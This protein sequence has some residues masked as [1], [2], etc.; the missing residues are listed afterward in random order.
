MRFLSTF[1]T[2][3]L[4]TLIGCSETPPP[5]WTHKLDVFIQQE[6]TDKGIPALSITIVDNHETVWTQGYGLSDPL[7]ETYVT[8]ETVYRVASISK[9]FTALAVMQL[10][11]Q[12][13]LDLDVPITTYLPDFQPH[14]PFDTPITLRHLLSH[15]S[16]LVREP[17]RGHYFDPDKPTLENVVHSLNNTRLIYKPGTHEK[18]SNAGISVA[19]YILEQTQ[20]QLFESYIQEAVIHPLKLEKTSF[21]PRQDIRQDLGIGYMWRYD[22]STLTQAPVF[23]LGI[24]PAANLYTTTHDLGQFICSLFAI[25]DGKH[26]DILQ[27]ETLEDM[28]TPQGKG[29]NFGLGFALSEFEQH[30]RVQHAGV[31]YGYATRVY[32]L[33]EQKIGVAIVANLDATNSVVDRIGEYA[34]SLALD[35]QSPPTLDTTE[36]PSS[37]EAHKLAGHYYRQNGEDKRVLIEQNGKL[38]LEQDTELH[39]VHHLQSSDDRVP[40]GEGQCIT[41]SRLGHGYKFQI[42]G[43]TLITADGTYIQQRPQKPA[44]ITEE[45]QNLMGEYGWNHNV[46]YVLERDKQLHILIEWFFRYPLYEVAPDSFLLPDQG[47][48]MGESLT[49]LRDT[50]ETVTGVSLA[51][52]I[53]PRRIVGPEDGHLF[54]ITPQ[55]S[56]DTL[57]STAFRASPPMEDGPFRTPDLVDITSIA[58]TIR[59]DIRYAT[60]NN[61]MG[62]PFYPFPKAYLQRPAA[63]ALA[64]VHKQLEEYG[65]GL[66]VYDGYRPWHVTKMFYDATPDS[67]QLFVAN[68]S[69]GSRHNRG[70]AVDLGLYILA[71]G[72]IIEMISDYDE[73]TTRAYAYYPGGSSLQ[74]FYRDLLRQKMEAANFT[75]YEAEWW[76]FDYAMWK[77]Y[78][79]LNTS[80]EK[81]P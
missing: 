55:Y 31:M 3:S 57:R 56:V 43:D 9:L 40:G 52:V 78:A 72:K 17:P 15:R 25:H 70:C 19:G 5:E 29:S 66:L 39:T 16:G 69:N 60:D 36:S 33:P 67:L 6:L 1:L 79:L 47:L 20:S 73:F 49:F 45:W 12:G 38:L 76:H 77:E 8:E 22:R 81:L 58:P 2:I 10:V 7:T 51:G 27:P 4:A 26:S 13:E 23:E 68:P 59:L 63:Q 62:T 48:Y 28:W 35:S 42:R 46:L 71:T 21:L 34:L 64:M 37:E 54:Q 75:V 11:E 50:E 53:F 74:H 65:L 32:A 80:F 44:P 24:G 14:N 30:Q 18:Y 41:N 61:F